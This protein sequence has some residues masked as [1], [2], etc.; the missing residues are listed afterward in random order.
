MHTSC[1]HLFFSRI[2]VAA[3]VELHVVLLFIM[4]I[5]VIR[6]V[7]PYCTFCV[8]CVCNTALGKPVPVG[9][10][11]CRLSLAYSYILTLR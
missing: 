7:Q 2:D 4:H 5:S 1:M 6:S 10:S 9:W 3:K 8:A 11:A